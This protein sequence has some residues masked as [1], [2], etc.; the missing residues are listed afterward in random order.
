[1]R[2]KGQVT[3]FIII[4]ILVVGAV[5][6]FFTMRGSL[7]RGEVVN[8]EVAP[9]VNFVDECLEDSLGDVVYRIGEGGGYYI[10]GTVS[11]VSGLEVP[12]YIKNN[13][14]LM[15]TKEQLESDISKYVSRDLVLCLGGFTLFP[16][17]EIT[18][19]K[20]KTETTIESD[21]VSIAVSYPLYVKKG[22]FSSKIEDFESEVPVRLGV[23]YD[24]IYEFIEQEK[25]TPSVECISCLLDILYENDLYGTTIY[26]DENTKLIIIRDFNSQINK[27]DFIYNFADEFK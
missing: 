4:A 20:M 24:A 3:I 10:S 1:M 16:E 8:P 21:R 12:Y 18:K 27:K 22:D 11:S 14:N 6:L 15:P 2:K 13:Q 19:G 26:S 17:Y 7:Q 25:E 5:A 9:I 23:V